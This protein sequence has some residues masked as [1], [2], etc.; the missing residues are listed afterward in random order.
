MRLP[1]LFLIQKKQPMKQLLGC[2]LKHMTPLKRMVKVQTLARSIKAPYFITV[3][4][5]K[6]LQKN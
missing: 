2:F 4:L 1:M 3:K 6:S 5:K